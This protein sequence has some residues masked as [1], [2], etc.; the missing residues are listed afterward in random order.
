MRKRVYEELQNDLDMAM[1]QRDDAL[2][3]LKPKLEF[4]NLARLSNLSK[5]Q[6]SSNEG[7]MK[8]FDRL[9]AKYDTCE[10]RIEKLQKKVREAEALWIDQMRLMTSMFDPLFV[11]IGQL[12]KLPSESDDSMESESEDINSIYDEAQKETD[13]E[14]TSISNIEKHEADNHMVRLHLLAKQKEDEYHNALANHEKHFTGLNH[15]NQ[16]KLHLRMMKDSS[17]TESERHCNFSLR[18]LKYGQELIQDLQKAEEE[19]Y[20]A[21]ANLRN[22]SLT[23]AM[24]DNIPGGSKHDWFYLDDDEEHEKR[25]QYFEKYRSKIESWMDSDMDSIKWEDSMAPLEP[26]DM[27]DEWDFDGEGNLVPVTPTKLDGLQHVINQEVQ[28]PQVGKPDLPE[29][30]AEE[31]E[32]EV[33]PLTGELCG[34]SPNATIEECKNTQRYPNTTPTYAITTPPSIPHLLLYY[35]P[36]MV[37]RHRLTI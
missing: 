32:V 12:R 13:S 35:P 29:L 19:L 11:D 18:F 5:E 24:C 17:L 4:E 16:L 9:Q 8:K 36:A 34:D 6:L 2:K 27:E 7:L 30:Q 20:E 15:H 1:F 23:P 10:L 31:E 3:A 14:Q 33:L 37:P 28:H 22:A 21:H 25:M 26:G